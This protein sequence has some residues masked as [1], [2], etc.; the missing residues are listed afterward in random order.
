LGGDYSPLMEDAEE[1]PQ[2][3]VEDYPGGY[4]EFVEDFIAGEGDG[5]E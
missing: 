4:P 1:G 5:A 2:K 3:D